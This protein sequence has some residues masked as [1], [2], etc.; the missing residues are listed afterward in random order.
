MLFNSIDFLFF[1]PIVLLVYFIIPKKIRYIWLLITSYYFYMCWNVKYI[2]LIAISTVIT[3]VSGILLEKF[4]QNK[5]NMKIIVAFSFC[6]NLGILFFYKYF[7]F[8]I[9][10]INRI[11]KIF[12][13]VT[14]TNK[15]DILLPVGISF[16]T[17][18]AL[19]YTIDVYR[20]NVKVE[21]NI[22]RYALFVSFFPQLVAGPIERSTNLIKQLDNLDEL[23][24][25]NLDRIFKGF[26][27]IVY[28]LFLKMVISDRISIL[29]D[30]VYNN[31]WMYGSIELILASIFFAI[32]IY[33][34]FS[35]YS[36]IA[37]GTAKILGV[38]LMEN[39][40]TPYFS[41]SV[42]EFWRRWHISLST[43][44]KDYLYIPLG[45]NRCSKGRHYINIMITFLVSGLWHG[46]NWSYV[47][48]GGLH[49]VY[50]IVES[51]IDKLIK[52][53][54]LLLG[55]KT[56]S[57]S[58][59]I[60]QVIITFIFV[61]IAWIFFRANS[62]SDALKIIKTIMVKWNPWCLFDETIYTL[63]LDRI[64]F[65]ILIVSLIVLF[66]IDLIKYIKN[67][68]LD[69]FLYNQCLWFRWGIVIILIMVIIIFGIY[70][71]TYDTKNFIYFQF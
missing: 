64:E 35:S 30:T 19:S 38:N 34:D 41:K 49:G 39:F 25:W 68:Q 59:K 11:L 23:K 4:Y 48:W 54:N 12:D 7:D 66:I 47:V 17:F 43:W 1:F 63:G 33:C 50:Q 58:Y 36:I 27:L 22:F 20:K 18:Q 32:Q 51:E 65:N 37:I 67:Q 57:E 60:A 28:G 69:S 46:A 26:I 71:P 3:F 31:Y 8:M 40:N 29:V 56:E 13:L 2:I 9:Q 44:F 70:G 24:L 15:F 5:K 10:N 16:Y 21:K 55:T 62:L 61:D 52:K 42:K 14:V 53:L 45:G 6:I